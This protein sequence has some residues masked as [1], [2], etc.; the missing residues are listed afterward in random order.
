MQAD[1]LGT[2]AKAKGG[3]AAPH[4]GF[5]GKTRN[6]PGNIWIKVKVLP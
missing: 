1:A 6:T 3:G 5:S 4:C 2:V